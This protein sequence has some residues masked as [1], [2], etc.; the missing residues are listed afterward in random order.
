MQKPKQLEL[1][2]VLFK[3]KHFTHYNTVMYADQRMQVVTLKII[4]SS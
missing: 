1:C 3:T 2:L 4:V